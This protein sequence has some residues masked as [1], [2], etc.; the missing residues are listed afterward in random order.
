MKGLLG[1]DVG[2][3]NVKAVLYDLSGTE[4]RKAAFD[5]DLE[6]PKPQWAEQDPSLWW[7][8]VLHCLKNLDL[9]QVDIEGLGVTG[10]MH[11]LVMLDGKD[12]VLRKSI[13]WCDQRTSREVEDLAAITGRNNLTMITGNPP[14][15]GFTAAK[16][17]WVRKNEPGLY[18]KCRKIMVTKDYIVFK[19]TGFYSADV[20]DASGMQFL[21]IKRRHWSK[22]L[23]RLLALPDN[24]LCPVHE[25]MAV[26]GKTTP[27]IEALTG[28]KAGTPVIAGAGDQAAAAIGNGVM[29]DKTSSLNL[30]SS[31]VI[32]AYSKEPVY[33][34]MGR[35]H[36][37]CHALPGVWHL[38]AVTQGAGLSLKWFKDN[39]YK[40]EQ[41]SGI[42]IYPLINKEAEAVPAGAEG[43][44]FLPYLMG[45]RS[46]ILDADAK[47]VFY[48]ISAK[49]TRAHF[50]RA[51][52]EGVA[53]SFRDCM[54]V[55]R[56]MG[57][58]LDS[59][60]FS[61]GGSQSEVWS[62]IIAS[63]TKTSL[64]RMRDAEAGAKGMAMLAGLATGV[65]HDPSAVARL[66]VKPGAPVVPDPE[67][68]SVY[69]KLYQRYKSV[70][71]AL[72]QVFLESK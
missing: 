65:Y 56:E 2:T 22:P 9:A 60:N 50:A 19:L 29:F 31:G 70:Y 10:Q 18:A 36:T 11:S 30:G 28:L 61:G 64:F 13:L 6:Q 58:K 27:E 48:G 57:V 24:I 23:L 4:V 63:A 32:F 68:E 46:P 49:H 34:L 25:S 45:E 14:I 42:G 53:L 44:M 21:D 52:M 62:A 38:M 47:G 54:D 69:D 40:E 12:Q 17:L 16:L 15:S 66:F 33:D 67:M 39:F 37:M 1:I 51:V 20:T 5:Y 72:R 59:M 35:V 41:K 7:Q 3:S 71:A 8:G 26:V 43:L 55:F